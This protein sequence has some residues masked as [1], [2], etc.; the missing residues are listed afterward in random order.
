MTGKKEPLRGQAST[1]AS[2]TCQKWLSW[3]GPSAL[4]APC[5]LWTIPSQS[6]RNHHPLHKAVFEHSIP[7]MNGTISFPK[8]INHQWQSNSQ[9]NDSRAET[10]YSVSGDVQIYCIYG[11]VQ[12]EPRT[13]RMP[14]TL[15]QHMIF[16][17]VLEF[18]LWV[19]YWEILHLSSSER[20]VY[21]FLL[22]FVVSL[23]DFGVRVTQSSLRV[24]CWP[25]S[26]AWPHFLPGRSGARNL[27]KLLLFP[28]SSGEC[29]SRLSLFGTE[30]VPCC[31]SPSPSQ[32]PTEPASNLPSYPR[33][34]KSLDLI[35]ECMDFVWCVCVCVYSLCTVNVHES[36]SLW[37]HAWTCR[38]Q[39]R[40]GVFGHFPPY[41]LDMRSLTDP[42][43]WHGD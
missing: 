4:H 39:S 20:I 31:P 43:T 27:C 7:D 21:N 19:L 32:H 40:S 3:G 11:F 29:S 12:V 18:G 35:K 15:L 42:D 41:W 33:T 5:L 22:V 17:Y 1:C 26:S 2:L 34:S 28:A 23:C 36:T 8:R 24:W 6:L 38:S 16:L 13:F 14:S 25:C 9:R 30:S 10:K 37:A